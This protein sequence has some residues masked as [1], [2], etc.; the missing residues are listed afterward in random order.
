MNYIP[1]D[2]NAGIHNFSVY[3]RKSIIVALMSMAA[4]GAWLGYIIDSYLLIFMLLVVR[5]AA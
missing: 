3:Y 1:I 4:G 2:I 5:I